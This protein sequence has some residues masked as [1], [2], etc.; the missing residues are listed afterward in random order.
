[1]MHHGNRRD[2]T[3]KPPGMKILIFDL[4]IESFSKK[5]KIQKLKNEIFGRK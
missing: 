4:K 2:I 3:G 1:M 5:K